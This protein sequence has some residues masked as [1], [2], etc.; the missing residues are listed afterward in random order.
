MSTPQKSNSSSGNKKRISSKAEARK[1]TNREVDWNLAGFDNLPSRRGQRASRP[2]RSEKSTASVVLCRPLGQ[3][4]RLVPSPKELF[5]PDDDSTAVSSLTADS[6]SSKFY[7]KPPHTRVIIEVNVSQALVND[8]LKPCP[9]CGRSTLAISFPTTCVASGCLISCLHEFCT[10]AALAPPAVSN[11]PLDSHASDK[12]KRNTDHAANI[13]FVL[14][15]VASGDGGTEAARVLGLL[16]LPN[17]TTMQSRSFGTIEKQISPAINQ[18]NEEILMDNLRQEVALFYGDDTD[19]NGVKLYDRWNNDD[20]PE[21]AMWPHIDGCA[22]MGWQQKGSGRKR[23][24]QSG[25]ALVIAMKTR[26]AIAKSV[27]SKGCGYCK[28]WYTTNTVDEEPPD[29]KCYKNFDGPSSGAMEPI[30]VLDMYKELY[31]KRVIVRRFVADDDSSIK[32]KLKWSNPNYKLNTGTTNAPKIINGNGNLVPR[33]NHGEVPRHMPE[34]SFVA[35]PNHRRK[36]LA[37]VLYKFRDRGKL[38]PEE[39]RSNYDRLC[40]NRKKQGKEPPPP[41][42]EKKWNLT[43]TGMDVRRLSKN[44][45]FMARKLQYLNTDEEILSA[46]EAVL[47]PLHTHHRQPKS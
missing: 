45:A 37:G 3:T 30:A 26:K 6:S 14:G 36:T 1:L 8:Y 23:N 9:T 25:H 7:K 34:P 27:L 11:V 21:Q 38:S 44:F 24:S 28:K 19:M 40:K 39:Q 31:D 42:K 47:E 18:F 16:G 2:S 13:L 4:T 46:G 17:S 43:L 29:H 41:F 15:F 22:D 33:P 12:V 35:D 20:L 32:A 10:F 5:S